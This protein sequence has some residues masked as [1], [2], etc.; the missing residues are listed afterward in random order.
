[1][2]SLTVPFLSDN[3]AE[4]SQ[5]PSVLD[6]ATVRWTS[7]DNNNWANAYPYAPKAVFRIAH[8]RDAFLIEYCAWDETVRA[9]NANDNGDV[10]TDSCME[11]FL[12]PQPGDGIYYNLECN[13]IG[14]V[15]LGVRGE[16]VAK[17]HA[18]AEVL[19]LIKRWS[20][21]G[22]VPFEEFAIRQP[23]HVALVVPFAVYW[24]HDISHLLAQ[25]QTHMRANF[26]KCGDGL[27]KPH[28]LSWS[29][30]K[31]ETPNFHL[32]EFFGEIV[33]APNHNTNRHK[34]D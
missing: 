30:I 25:G 12:T 9:R 11:F 29:P 22:H 2:K 33:L 14:T 32:P 23:W 17:S 26:Y 10:W 18:S 24:H 20:S 6:S 31:S 4:A 1:M 28:F 7:V 15:L 19:G 5:I 16:N 21:L 27:K 8:T 34:Q 13:C 3:V